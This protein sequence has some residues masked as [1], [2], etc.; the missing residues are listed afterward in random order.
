MKKIIS[1][2][3]L[4]IAIGITSKAQVLSVSDTYEN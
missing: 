4:F 2:I 3:V 1:I